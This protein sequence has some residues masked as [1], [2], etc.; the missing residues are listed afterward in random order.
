MAF[1]DEQMSAARRMMR[2]WLEI[3]PG[4]VV[5]TLTL[6]D[7]SIPETP[8]EEQV[9]DSHLDAMFRK[10]PH[11]VEARVEYLAIYLPALSFVN[12]LNAMKELEQVWRSLPE[13]DWEAVANTHHVVGTFRELLSMTCY[14]LHTQ[15][16]RRAFD[17]KRQELNEGIR[18]F[19][20]EIDLYPDWI[21]PNRSERAS[22]QQE[23]AL[24]KAIDVNW[25][26]KAIEDSQ[27]VEQ[28]VNWGREGNWKK[29]YHQ[30]YP[31]ERWKTR[32]FARIF[33]KFLNRAFSNLTDVFELDFR[34]ESI[35]GIRRYLQQWKDFNPDSAVPLAREALLLRA[36]QRFVEAMEPIEAALKLSPRSPDVLVES[37][38]LHYAVG[39]REQTAELLERAWR[40]LPEMEWALDPTF[41]WLQ[42]V[43]DALIALTAA[44]IHEVLG[45]RNEAK[46]LLKDGIAILEQAPLCKD[47]LR[48]INQQAC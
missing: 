13:M 28:I 10:H 9:S 45:E 34:R 2:S 19:G 36:E 20:L 7:F 41:S 40:H 5:V 38:L 8:D 30:L 16:A 48:A 15:S 21:P 37:A 29:V 39:N 47:R 22:S 3:E 18:Q 27:V 25:I 6:H 12:R 33:R 1:T 32:P 17:R 35:A 46:E 43:F 26:V 4:D 31:F 14:M 44:L 23:N 24:L 42:D 11:A